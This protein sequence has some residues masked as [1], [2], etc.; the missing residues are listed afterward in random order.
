MTTPIPQPFYDWRETRGADE[1]E[2]A[3]LIRL[4]TL[5]ARAKTNPIHAE[6]IGDADIA[7]L[8]DLAKLPLLRKSDLIGMQAQTPPFAELNL[9]E[10]GR[11]RH[12]YR[13]PGP[14]NDYDG[15]DDSHD[16]GGDGPDWWRVGRALYA[17]GFRPGDI[18][19]NSFSYHFTPA[20]MMFDRGATHIGCAVFPAGTENTDLQAQAMGV[21]GATAYTG[22]PD[23]LPRLLEKADELGIDTRT[24]TRACVSAGPLFPSVREG[25]ERR[26]I[27]VR[28]CYVI[29]DLGLVAYETP[30]LAA[31]VID[32]D[33]I[34]EIVRPGTGDPVP[35]GEV[36]EVVVTALS[37]H[38]LPLIRLA[39]G[40]LSAI[41]LGQ[42]PCGRT[43]RRIRGWLGRADQTVKVRGM[44]VRPEQ[45][46]QALR[47]CGLQG[48]AR[49]V[50]GREGGRDTMTLHVEH[51][52]DA[53]GLE[54]RI[55]AAIKTTFNLRSEVRIEPVGSLAND[56]KV[57][58][59]RRDFR[60]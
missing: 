23:F 25:L 36:G 53:E 31:M 9:I 47:Q 12:L 11:M 5:I 34:V 24:L 59:D 16:P 44:F 1:R 35:E 14:I 51:D 57:I 42:S 32:E 17:A 50:V 33:I 39:I 10:P 19:H 28:Q 20:G 27:A 30:A 46:A 48:R 26:G 7:S 3:Q 55:Q 18:V 21:F 49:L 54:G 8:A 2:A 52:S 15:H 4:Q 37:H 41:A 29:A 40:D 60:E 22:V 58:E 43:G 13:S 45:V 6:R 56:G 38:E